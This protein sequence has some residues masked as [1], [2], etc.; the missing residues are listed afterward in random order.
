MGIM[1]KKRDLSKVMSKSFSS[2]QGLGDKAVSL[3]SKIFHVFDNKLTVMIVPH[4][5]GKVV[6]FQT[7]VFAMVLG[8]MIALGIALSFIFFN[9]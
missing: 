1:A 7:N 3:A 5:Q 4:A 6:N 8:I 9:K 2:R